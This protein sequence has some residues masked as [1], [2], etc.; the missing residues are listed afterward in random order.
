[1]AQMEISSGKKIYMSL[2]KSSFNSKRPGLMEISLRLPK[3]TLAGL[4]H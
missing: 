4:D 2:Y 1:M 3:F